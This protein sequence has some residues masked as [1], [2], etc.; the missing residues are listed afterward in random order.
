MNSQIE[1]RKLFYK[2]LNQ[3]NSPFLEYEVDLK[4]MR[5]RNKRKNKAVCSRG[6]IKYLEQEVLRILRKN[7]QLGKENES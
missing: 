3:G 1:V 4:S 2:F 5:Y 7:K 6:N